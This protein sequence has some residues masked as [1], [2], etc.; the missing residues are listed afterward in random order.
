MQQNPSP[1][2]VRVGRGKPLC[3]ACLVEDGG[4]P[5]IPPGPSVYLAGTQQDLT[6]EAELLCSS[7]APATAGEHRRA[8]LGAGVLLLGP[9]APAF[10]FF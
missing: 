9:L 3:W 2:E 6:L 10:S 1:H 4:R 5:Q 8:S 7:D